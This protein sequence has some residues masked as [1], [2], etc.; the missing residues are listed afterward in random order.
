MRSLCVRCK[1][2][3]TIEVEWHMRFVEMKGNVEL[4]EHCSGFCCSLS[5]SPARL[6]R[7]F[8]GY[9]FRLRCF[10]E[11]V[12]LWGLRIRKCSDPYG[13][14]SIF[15][16]STMHQPQ[17]RKYFYALH[18]VCGTKRSI[19]IGIIW[20][21]TEQGIINYPFTKLFFSITRYDVRSMNFRFFE[22]VRS[23]LISF[24]ISFIRFCAHDER[25]RLTTNIFLP[26]V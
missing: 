19:C 9:I 12:M 10:T 8:C 4:H 5:A 20:P 26:L 22:H 23:H 18:S 14:P 16:R 6:Q 13:V 24:A 17:E 15:V 21:T 1:R 7:N 2:A 25:E 3:V 11:W